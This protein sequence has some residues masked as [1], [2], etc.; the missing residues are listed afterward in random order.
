MNPDE[1]ELFAQLE[2]VF[3]AVEEEGV[4]NLR[5]V[6][7]DDLLKEF[8]EI[9]DYIMHTL[10]QTRF[11]VTQEGRDAHARRNALQLELRRRGIEA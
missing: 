4:Q 8:A 1:K 10:G 9:T 11:P 5:D 2:D 3:Q 7:L 6:S